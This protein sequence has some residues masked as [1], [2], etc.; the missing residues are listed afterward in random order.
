M[1]T[2]SALYYHLIWST[3]NRAGFISE[4]IENKLHA[5]MT[6]IV[7]AKNGTVIQIGGMSDHV[8][9][10]VQLNP[11]QNIS[12][13]VK[14]VKVASSK[15]L[16]ETSPDFNK[17]SWQ[18]GFGAFSVST[19]QTDMVKEYILNQKEHHKIRGFDEEWLNFLKSHKIEYNENFVLG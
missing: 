19:S 17:F 8:H 1:T 15:W 14:T 9:L 3:K 10:L 7:Q 5:Y 18:T 2:Y 12:D 13:L 11:D 16:K 6:G 4:T